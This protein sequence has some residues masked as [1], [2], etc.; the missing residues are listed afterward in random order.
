MNSHK[1]NQS[2]E[3]QRRR[4]LT[5]ACG[6]VVSPDR[7]CAQPLPGALRVMRFTRFTMGDAQ[8]FA[9]DVSNFICEFRQLSIDCFHQE[10]HSGMVS[11]DRLAFYSSFK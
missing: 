8:L 1:N 7:H 4:L 10:W 9:F 3:H 5:V 11:R 2:D 6:A